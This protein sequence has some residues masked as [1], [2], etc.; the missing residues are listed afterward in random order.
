MEKGLTGRE[1]GEVE[2][3]VMRDIQRLP[4]RPSG[5]KMKKREHAG[6]RSFCRQ[7]EEFLF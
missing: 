2:E 5:L 3:A 1:V 4:Q 7:L 6:K